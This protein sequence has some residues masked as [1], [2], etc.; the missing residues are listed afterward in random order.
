MCNFFTLPIATKP[1]TTPFPTVQR[2][3]TLIARE[4]Y[5]TQ[6]NLISIMVALLGLW[7]EYSS[8]FFPCLPL[9]LSHSL[10]LHL[11]IYLSSSSSLPMGSLCLL[12]GLTTRLWQTFNKIQSV[13]RR[14]CAGCISSVKLP[15]KRYNKHNYV[16]AVFFRSFHLLHASNI[17]FI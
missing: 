9:S 15:F 5:S 1:A 4:V 14:G 6:Y 8:L 10:P 13:D 3:F 16:I 17:L 11:S 7:T 2:K 12:T